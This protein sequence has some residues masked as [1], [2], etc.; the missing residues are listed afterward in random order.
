MAPVELQRAVT[1]LTN[2]KQILM[3]V[4]TVRLAGNKVIFQII[5]DVFELRLE[6]EARAGLDAGF[7]LCFVCLL[8]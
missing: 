3:F 5:Y 1:N 8:S 7:G 2:Q 4:I 6:F